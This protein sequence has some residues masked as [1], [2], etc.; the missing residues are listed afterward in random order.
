VLLDRV[1]LDTQFASCGDGY[2]EAT[3]TPLG[4]LHLTATLSSA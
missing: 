2:V 4:V 3:P 1:Y